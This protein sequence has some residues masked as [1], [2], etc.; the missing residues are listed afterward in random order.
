MAS[1]TQVPTPSY[2][3][4]EYD[5]YLTRAKARNAQHTKT[6][7]FVA[8]LALSAGLAAIYLGWTIMAV[9]LLAISVF[10][11][12]GSSHYVLLD[13]V[14]TTQWHLA[15]FINSQTKHLEALRADG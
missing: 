8:L 15:L 14:L 7:S 3:L 12:Q 10:F 1:P 2:T 6:L 4:Q 13:D 5:D 11:G 9:V